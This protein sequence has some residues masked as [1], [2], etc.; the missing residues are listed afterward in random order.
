M[1]IYIGMRGGGVGVLGLQALTAEVRR[2][3]YGFWCSR[4]GIL[5]RK[6]VMGKLDPV[7]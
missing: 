1:G 4:P 2:N 5:H 6:T 7:I 3:E